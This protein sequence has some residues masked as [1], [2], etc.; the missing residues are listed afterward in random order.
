MWR[1]YF[2]IV[3]RVVGIVT[4]DGLENLKL[5]FQQQIFLFSKIFSLA[6]GL[7]Q[8]PVGLVPEFSPWVKAA[9]L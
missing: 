3:I 6:L 1:S 4:R 8:P 9:R 7:T 2:I 5:K